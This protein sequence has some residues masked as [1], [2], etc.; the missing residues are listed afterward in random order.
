MRQAV[1][2]SPGRIEFRDI[3][4]SVPGAH[5]MLELIRDAHSGKK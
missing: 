4:V 5:E 1:I 3:P 2:V